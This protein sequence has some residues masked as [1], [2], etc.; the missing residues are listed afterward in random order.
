MSAGKA[1]SDSEGL[2]AVF[3]EPFYLSEQTVS[4]KDPDSPL[5][6][7]IQD[8]GADGDEVVDGGNNWKD[9]P[10]LLHLEILQLLQEEIDAVDGGELLVV[11]L[12]EIISQMKQDNEGVD[13]RWSD[14]RTALNWLFEE[15]LG[16]D[17]FNFT[18]STIL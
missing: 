10:S 17:L 18:A 15:N 13:V 5:R 16:D 2:Y 6:I 1:P 8:G 12:F 9:L 3:A 4:P 11:D 14:V 7:R